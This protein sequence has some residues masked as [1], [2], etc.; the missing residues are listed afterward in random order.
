MTEFVGNIRIL[1]MHANEELS[2]KEPEG[3]P[4][5]TAQTDHPRLAVGVAGWSYPDWRDTV[6]RLPAGP[7]QPGLFGDA[8]AAPRPRFA[9]DPLAFIRDYVDMVE[10]NSTFYR[11]P[12]ARTATEWARR[13]AERPGFFFTAKLNREFTHEFRRDR[14][15]A[16][17]FRQGLRPMADVGLLRALLVQFRYDFADSAEARQ[18]LLWIQSEFAEFAHLVVEV[19][20]A[21]WQAPDA[22]GFLAENGLSVANLDYPAGRDGFRLRYCVTHPFAYLRL[23][24]RNRD[25]WYKKA[26]APHEPYNYDYSDAEIAELASR[27]CKLSEQARETVVVA[28]NHY[29]GKAVSAALRLKAALSGN[30][31]SVPPA[32]L[33]TY[34]GLADIAHRTSGEK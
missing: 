5:K 19:R 15:L 8:G 22:L 14:A 32:L 25:A 12:S 23:H 18:L 13:G 24:G 28:N 3:A 1:A 27:V 17:D 11:A 4:T 2:G 34:P 7:R 31:V 9:P 10:V 33:Q 20:H 16:R 26:E 29:R 6:Y 30:R 21:S